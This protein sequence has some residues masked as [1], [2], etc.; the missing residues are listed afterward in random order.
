MSGPIPV[1]TEAPLWS[2]DRRYGAVATVLAL[3]VFGLGLL[4][5]RWHELGGYMVENDYYGQYLPAAH[6]ILDGEPMA[7]PRSGPGFPLL[8]AAGSLLTDD[9]FA[10]GKVVASLS[11]ALAGW[12]T[13][14]TVRAFTSAGA[15]LI[16]QLFV[17]AILGRF[18]IVVGNDLPFVAVATAS[19]YFLLRRQDPGA[20]GLI[21]A[22]AF[23][24]LAMSLR[25]PGVAL[26]PVAIL[27]LWL[28]PI[29]ATSWRH[30]F[31]ASLLYALP[32]VL[33][34]A[35]SWAASSLGLSSGKESKAYAFVALDVY[36]APQDRLS[37][38]HLDD[39]EVRFHSMW[40]VLT[41]DPK[42]VVSHYALDVFDDAF[43]IAQDSVTLPAV[44]FVGAGFLLWFVTGGAD[45]RRAAAFLAFALVTFGI[46]ALVPYQ[47]RYGFAL[48]P[49]AAALVG[50][51][52]AHPWAGG[53][54]TGQPARVSGLQR[55]VLALC[56]L[57]P[58]AMTAVKLREY[59]TTEPVELLA[60]AE[61]LRPLVH[62]GDRVIARKAHLPVLA[63]ATPIFPKQNLELDEFLHWARHDAHA[64]FL[65]VGEWEGRTNGALRPL[66][67]GE[68]PAGLVL[69]WRHA[70]PAH[71][72]YEI[73]PE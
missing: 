27:A 43:H 15:A 48:V 46:V 19:L 68:P 36:A 22:G 16:A 7:N 55:F 57:P 28:W 72:L 6:A 18:G 71:S 9:L 65:L 24:G 49:A 21:L 66:I 52:F 8:L 60:G 25:Y 62:H 51:T 26:V 64:R 37:Q 50:A 45:R 63:G 69:R 47:A 41:R 11:L 67:D 73:L 32:A 10:F 1:S 34:S 44:L 54:T 31:G 29:P 35:P 58:L 33:A 5:G 12:F 20:L 30:R 42:R 17:Y 53:G 39:M 70:A 3:A 59:L 23:A 14:L 40:D 38:T 56:F 13:F 4:L 61:V 2:T